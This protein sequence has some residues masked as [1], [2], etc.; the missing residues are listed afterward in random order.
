MIYTVLYSKKDAQVKNIGN[1]I[2]S[3]IFNKEAGL[4]LYRDI[5][6]REVFEG[7][8]AFNH[9]ILTEEEIKKRSAKYIKEFPDAEI[10]SENAERQSFIG[11]LLVSGDS[12]K[13]NLGF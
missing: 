8:K 11:K 4:P 7:T 5:D 9:T 1:V 6:T 2:L 3:A 13:V 12:P 10:S